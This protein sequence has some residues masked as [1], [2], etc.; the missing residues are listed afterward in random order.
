MSH[1]DNSSPEIAEHEFTF[2][3]V[4]L[5]EFKYMYSDF[6]RWDCQPVFTND[7]KKVDECTVEDCIEID[8]S[9]AEKCEFIHEL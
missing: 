8:R 4:L 5:S 6:F 3:K 1:E 2:W 9:E 7:C